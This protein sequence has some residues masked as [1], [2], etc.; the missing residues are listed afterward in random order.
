LV[1]NLFH[2]FYPFILL[3]YFLPTTLS[4]TL[5]Y[6]Y[7]RSLPLF[8]S[9]FLP[10]FF[11]LWMILLLYLFLY[12]SLWGSCECGNESSGST[13]HGEFLD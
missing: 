2:V 7:F 4:S 8:L 1:I 6:F 3:S 12:F 5:V 9:N 10:L 11:I 13:K